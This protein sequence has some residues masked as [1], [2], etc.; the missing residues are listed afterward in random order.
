[1]TNNNTPAEYANYTSPQLSNPEFDA[2][3]AAIANCPA[4]PFDALDQITE[5]I[6]NNFPSM[7]DDDSLDDDA[8]EPFYNF[9]R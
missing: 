5:T 6:K 2:I 7:N 9:D 3:L 4:L 8:D 1:M